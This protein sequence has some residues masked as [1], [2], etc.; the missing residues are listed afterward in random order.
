[1][2]IDGGPFGGLPL[3]LIA[4]MWQETDPLHSVGKMLKGNDTHSESA[5]NHKKSFALSSLFRLLYF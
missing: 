2:S 3:F 5:M 4:N 1:M